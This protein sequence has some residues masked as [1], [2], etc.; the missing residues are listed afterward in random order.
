QACK[1]K[2]V[3][4]FGLYYDAIVDWPE[5][6]LQSAIFDI[7]GAM[8]TYLQLAID[9]KLEGK[10]YNFDLSTPEA[11]RLGTFNPA[12][13]KEVQDEVLALAEKMKSGELKP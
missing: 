8:L 11:A 7:K 13:P 10:N 3:W 6:V 12:V 1:E 5:T 9:G 4:A 2:G